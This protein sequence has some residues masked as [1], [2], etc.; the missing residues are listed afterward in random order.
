MKIELFESY[1]SEENHLAELERQIA[2]V[3]EKLKTPART[4]DDIILHIRLIK[5]KQNLIKP[6]CYS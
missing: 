6:L 2:A 3:E 1:T 5:E 4:V